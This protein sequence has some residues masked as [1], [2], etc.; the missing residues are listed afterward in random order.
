MDYIKYFD[1]ERFLFE[2]VHQRFHENHFLDAFD[3]F[4]IIIWKANRA[5]SKI[6]KR[7]LQEN[8]PG[9][10]SLEARCRALTEALYSE[11]TPK[12][13]LRL[14]IKGWGFAL[15]MASAILTVCWPDEFTIYDYRVREL[16]GELPNLGSDFEAQ[17]KFFEEYKAQVIAIT[18]ARDLRDKDRY[19]SGKSKANQLK[20]DILESFGVK[21]D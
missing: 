10:R 6:A 2:D 20:N 19:L 11:P 4:S 17:W 1:S 5:K 15:P 14:L 3:F 21:L 8:L 16:L 7:M 18:E 12:E 13:R 9:E